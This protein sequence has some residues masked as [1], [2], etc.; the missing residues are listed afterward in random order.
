MSARQ[1]DDNECHGTACGD[2]QSYRVPGRT[3]SCA[4]G[5][6]SA[7]SWQGVSTGV[8][9]RQQQGFALIDMLFVCGVIGLLCS[10]AMPRLFK[11]R[12]AAGSASAIGTLRAI[13]SGQLTFALT[14][15]AGF[16]APNLISLGR[17]PIGSNEG[18]IGGGLGT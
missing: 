10:I 11:A 5:T 8:R 16:Y 4:R 9:I 3:S 13:S 1:A 18:F 15:G 6:S 2:A 17:P 12:Q 14:C 7:V